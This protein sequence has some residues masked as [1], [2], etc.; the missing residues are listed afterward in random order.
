MAGI[1]LSQWQAGGGSSLPPGGNIG[2]VLTK[3]DTGYDWLPPTGGSGGT[4]IYV[5]NVTTEM[6]I[7]TIPLSQVS[8][9]DWVL[10]ANSGVNT[11]RCTVSAI[12]GATDAKW[13]TYA[14]LQEGV[15]DGL[16]IRVVK[17]TATLELLCSALIPTDFIVLRQKVD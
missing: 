10:Y 4:I 2:D 16:T 9:C 17:Q 11:R 6:I 7:D 13:S 5:D 8:S 15:I 12:V 1:W 14:V 3:T